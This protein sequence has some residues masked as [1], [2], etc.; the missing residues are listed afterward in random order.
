MQVEMGNCPLEFNKQNKTKEEPI[1]IQ[2]LTLEN[3][4]LVLMFF[5]HLLFF[6][7]IIIIC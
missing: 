6:T 3:C 2:V 7:I 1:C 4:E 5:N